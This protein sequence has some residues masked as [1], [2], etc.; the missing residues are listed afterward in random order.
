[1]SLAPRFP[2]YIPSKSRWDSRITMRALDAMK[3]PYRVIVE[4]QQFDAYASV[5]PE[6]RLIVLDPKFQDEYDPCDEFGRSKS[7]GS[8]PARNAA[9]AD[10]Q[11]RG[12]EWHWVVDDNI[13]GW[14][15][16]LRNRRIRAA[17]AS[18]FVAMEDFATRYR[19]VAMAGP[20]Y[21]GFAPGRE[22][23]PPFITGTRIYSCNLIRTAAPFRWRARYNEDVDLSLRMLKAGWNTVQ[24][25]AVLQNKAVTQT[26]KGGNTDEL[27]AKGT[28]AKSSMIVALHPDCARLSWRYGREHHYVDYG[29]WRNRPLIVDPNA[30]PPRKWGAPSIVTAEGR[31][32]G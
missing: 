25:Y 21:I 10:A 12:H 14:Y 1:M 32:D 3:V 7:L 20:T 28:A 18:P 26:V 22:R 15:W 23:F 27:Y 30:P 2:I 31:R 19:N 5:I 4:A 9:W 6:D 24:F 11:A 13:D 29:R 17:D 8:G 16:R